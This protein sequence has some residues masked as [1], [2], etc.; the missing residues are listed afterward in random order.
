M[1]DISKYG[2]VN[3]HSGDTSYFSAPETD[4]DPNLFLGQ[5]L[6]P[7]VR[8][9][10]LRI[11]FEYLAVRYTNPQKWAHVWLAGSGVSYQWAASREPGDLDC[12]IGIDY[13]SFRQN[14][15]EYSG[16]SDREIASTFNEDFSADL[17]PKTK[18]W[19][20]YEL[21]FYVNPQSN[22][23]DI[24]PYAAYSLTKDEW[25]VEPNPHQAPLFTRAWEQKAER[26]YKTAR[27][28]INRYSQALTDVKATGNPA[29]R[30]NAERRLN[31]A[32]SQAVAFYEDIHAG[33][34]I[35]FS[36]IGQGYTDYNNYRWQAGKRSGVVQALRTIKDYKDSAEKAE[37]LDTYGVELPTSETLI[38]RTAARRR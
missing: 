5:K 3:P 30:I 31:E 23:K 35:A 6:R 22:I 21:T 10:V 18:N 7:W 1:S 33:R 12:L 4:L 9:G 29:Y 26:D 38:R 17:M 13:V 28:I 11:L 15:L 19:H 36:Q 24:N 8:N 2:E 34:K 37:Q 16:L 27:D 25:E 32:I 20:G 14:N